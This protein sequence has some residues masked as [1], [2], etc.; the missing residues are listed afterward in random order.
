M[1]P[2]RPKKQSIKAITEERQSELNQRSESNPPH[3]LMVVLLDL[4]AQLPNAIEFA[5]GR[6]RLA[7]AEHCQWRSELKSADV[8][9]RS[10]RSLSASIRVRIGIRGLE[11]IRTD[12][13]AASV[14]AASHLPLHLRSVKG[15]NRQALRIRANHLLRKDRLRLAMVQATIGG[16]GG[17]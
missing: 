15:P 5:N 6:V 7:R 4:P 13:A 12:L 1:G 17:G 2:R 3:T 10:S 16:G 14:V 8:G 11:S 9:G